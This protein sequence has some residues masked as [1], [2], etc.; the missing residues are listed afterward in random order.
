MKRW[1]ILLLFLF[2]A[3]KPDRRKIKLEKYMDPSLNTHWL[4]TNRDMVNSLSF[5]LPGNNNYNIITKKSRCFSVWSET[6]FESRGNLDKIF[7][8]QKKTSRDHAVFYKRIINCRN[9]YFNN[10]IF[11]IFNRWINLLLNVQNI[12]PH[13]INFRER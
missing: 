6:N 11:S 13:K 9:L 5:S 4:F 10:L 3:I 1:L 12:S 7:K 2:E 8:L